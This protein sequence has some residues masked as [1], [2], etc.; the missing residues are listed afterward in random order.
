MPYV[1]GSMRWLASLSSPP[2]SPVNSAN[3]VKLLFYVAVISLLAQSSN[4]RDKEF[5]PE[6]DN[7]SFDTDLDKSDEEV[8]QTSEDWIRETTSSVTFRKVLPMFASTDEAFEQVINSDVIENLETEELERISKKYDTNQENEDENHGD[9]QLKNDQKNERTKGR[10]QSSEILHRLLQ[11]YRVKSSGVF[12]KRGQGPQLSIVNP[13]DVLRQRLLLELARR[14][15]KE[16]QDQIQANAEILKKI[17]KRSVA[18]DESNE[19]IPQLSVTHSAKDLIKRLINKNRYLE[20][21]YKTEKYR[22]LSRST[23]KCQRCRRKTFR[24]FVRY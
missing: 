9:H 6:L 22:S 11:T 23:N 19:V 7:I 10:S 24:P 8:P 14:R 16:N 1:Y 5:I 20:D 3:S 17:G 13:L 12:S 21:S 18:S 2:A 15:M 4:S